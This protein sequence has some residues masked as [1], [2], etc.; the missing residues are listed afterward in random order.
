MIT[1]F[2]KAKE[3][4]ILYLVVGYFT[5]LHMVVFANARMGIPVLPYMIIFAIAG[6]FSISKLLRKADI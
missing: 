1:R 2:S 3:V 6:I 4:L 5:L